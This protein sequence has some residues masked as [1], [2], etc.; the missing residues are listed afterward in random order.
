MIDDLINDI[1][2]NNFISNNV[3]VILAFIYD[4][5]TGL[6]KYF[7]YEDIIDALISNVNELK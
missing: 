3:Q 4:I 6:K 1:S 5:E 7:K 2:N